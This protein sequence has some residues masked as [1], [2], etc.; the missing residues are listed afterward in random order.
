MNKVAR[1]EFKEQLFAQLVRLG[2]GGNDFLADHGVVSRTCEGGWPSG[3][4][5]EE[6][7]SGVY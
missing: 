5:Q 6:G 2:R 1:G 3:S 7:E 4:T